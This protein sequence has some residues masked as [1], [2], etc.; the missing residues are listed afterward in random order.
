VLETRQITGGAWNRH[1]Y[2][3]G[4]VYHARPGAQV[5]L[6]IA[7]PLLHAMSKPTGTVPDSPPLVPDGTWSCSAYGLVIPHG[8]QCTGTADDEGRITAAV[9]TYPPLELLLLDERYPVYVRVDSEGE[10]D[11]DRVWVR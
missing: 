7:S 9:R 8:Y 4:E 6:R 11:S 2:V 1:D 5:R 3:A 10:N